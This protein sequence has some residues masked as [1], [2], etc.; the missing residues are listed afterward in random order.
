MPAGPAAT[1]RFASVTVTATSGDEGSRTTTSSRGPRAA[2]AGKVM[3]LWI[4][5]CGITTPEDAERVVMAGADAIGVN[6]VPSSKRYVDETT[7]RRVIAAVAG[8]LEVIAVVA[9]A[10][11]A[12]LAALRERLG[13]DA[14]Q[15]HGSEPPDV[16]ERLL[17]KAYQALR[18]A[19]AADV[20][21]A[22]AYGGSRLLVD[23]KVQGELGGTG[24]TFDWTLVKD[25]ARAR[26][27]V[28]AGGLTAENVGA[29]VLAVRPY[30]VDT[31]SG[32]EGTDPRRKDPAKITQFIARARAAAAG[33]GLDTAAGVD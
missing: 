24:Q 22:R 32:V 10:D 3:S 1:R 4:K 29:A 6:L 20:A 23:A 14:L 17:P 2:D 28:V 13:V 12:E 15:L 9:D 31:A 26:P 7:V 21:A 25:L 30:G 16:L 18:I 27:V 33:A 8:K 5:I 11:P 19:T